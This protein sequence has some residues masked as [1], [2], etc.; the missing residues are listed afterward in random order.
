MKT[1]LFLLAA[2]PAT[3]LSLT[4]ACDAGSAIECA[5]DIDCPAETPTC[6][7]S[8][9]PGVCVA[10]SEPEC[11]ENIECQ[12]T[13]FGDEDACDATSD[14]AAGEACVDGSDATAH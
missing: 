12:V 11:T 5:S 7:L 10:E 4:F 14:C 6:D 1:K 13:D 2:I 8:I 3:V 9:D